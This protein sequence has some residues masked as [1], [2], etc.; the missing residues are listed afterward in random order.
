MEGEG[1]EAPHVAPGMAEERREA[2]A[3]HEHGDPPEQH[4]ERVPHRA[5]PEPR[6]RRGGAPLGLRCHR[7]RANLGAVE[8][9]GVPV[10][11][12]VGSPPRR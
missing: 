11:E 10:M 3:D 12:V 4:V 6:E 9:R 7:E 1:E 2:H 5:V 8:L